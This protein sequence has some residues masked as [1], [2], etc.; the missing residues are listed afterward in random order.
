MPRKVSK[1]PFEHRISTIQREAEMAVKDRPL[2][3]PKS[4]MKHHAKPD[5]YRDARRWPNFFE[6]VYLHERTPP[7]NRVT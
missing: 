3:A 1:A 2:F 6:S 7:T 5:T 4:L